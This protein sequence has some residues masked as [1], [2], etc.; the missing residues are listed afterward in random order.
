MGMHKQLG[1]CGMD[2]AE[3]LA[4]IA[5][6]ADDDEER[7][8]VADKWSKDYNYEFKPE[9]INCDGC[10]AEGRHTA[11]C[12]ICEIRKCGQDQGVINCAYCSNYPCEKLE[13]FYKIALDAKKTLDDEKHWLD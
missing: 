6:Q 11:H 12:N 5:T 1:Y 4:Y 2:C 13:E 8:E 3:C 9:D 7:K 10:I